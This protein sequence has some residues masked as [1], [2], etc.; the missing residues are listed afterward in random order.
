MWPTFA[1]RLVES[2]SDKDPGVKQAAAFGLIQA[3]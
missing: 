1:S 2:L 3:R